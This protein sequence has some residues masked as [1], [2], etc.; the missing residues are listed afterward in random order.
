MGGMYKFEIAH[1]EGFPLEL[2]RAP[3]KVQNAYGKTILT[4]LRE[5]P[6][7]QDPPRI[8]RLIGFKNLWRLR[9]SDTYRLVYQVDHQQS[10]V[11][12]LMLDHRGKV[13]DRLGVDV[14]GQRSTRIVTEAPELLEPEPTPEEKGNALIVGGCE[15]PE[16]P[17]YADSPLPRALTPERLKEIGIPERYFTVLGG[18]TTEGELI[19]M[20]DKRVPA[21]IVSRVLDF[22]WP[23]KIEE[24]IQEPVRVAGQPEHLEEAA[25]GERSLESFLLKLDDDQK[26][27][28]SRFSGYRPT[29]PWLLKGGPGSGKSTVALYCIKELL[30]P[31]QR[32]I[33]TQEAPL[34]I[35]LTTY[36]NSL[37][38]ASGHLL[39]ELNGGQNDLHVTVRTVDSLAWGAI[40]DQLRRLSLA[41]RPKDLK[42]TRAAVQACLAE[43]KNYKFSVSD[44]EFLLSEIEW[45]IIGQDIESQEAYLKAVRTGRGR[46]LTENQRQHVWLTYKAL[47]KELE[48]ENMCLFSERL[49]QA[50]RNVKPQF[51]YVFIDE[52]Q[53]LKPVAIRFCI[54][55][56]KDP[57]NV[58]LTADS[59]Q[60]I[61][62]T[63]LSWS[64]VATDLNF[65]GRAKILK[66]NYRTTAE[67]WRSIYPLADGS[68]GVDSDTLDVEPVFNGPEPVLVRYSSRDG[69]AER[70]NSYLHQS[71]REQRV[72][73][74]GAAVLCPTNREMDEVMRMLDAR[75]NA[76]KMHSN[77]VNLS[78]PGVKVMTMHAA[79][80][81]QFPVVAVVGLNKGRLPLPTPYGIS[82]EE[83]IARH[84]R[85]FFVACSRAMR[86]LIVFTDRHRPSPFVE[87]LSDDH[88]EFEDA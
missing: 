79:K 22:L 46:K 70:L 15:E 71:L 60:S 48:R 51:D 59:N 28:V 20:T 77:Q 58:F 84:Q 34:R 57:K 12:I 85:L 83:H 72:A 17:G 88:W 73:I 64:R 6:V 31:G 8:K 35:L 78:H 66:R 53:D 5:R 11:T 4:A 50:S 38:N 1:A 16:A 25:K 45:V 41:M 9:V 27:F 62:G 32:R 74:N 82:E 63:G 86:N 39:K 7:E 26:T 54:G 44:D 80:G 18:A 40:P 69:M 21:D 36:T 65:Q 76:A 30:D 52:A 14:D 24:I 23:K 61:Y 81:L 43:S 87:K 2:G 68:S 3:K 33:D 19:G 49:R 13:Y 67:I 75:Y 29:G 37:V 47:Q 42:L 56:C 55:Q 10:L